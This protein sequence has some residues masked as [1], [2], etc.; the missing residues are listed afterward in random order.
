MDFRIFATECR[1]KKDVISCARAIA[2]EDVWTSAKSLGVIGAKGR[3]VFH[4]R[5]V[6][7]HSEDTT[8]ALS[9]VMCALGFDGTADG[10]ES[11][12]FKPRFGFVLE[13]VLWMRFEEIG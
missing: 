8:A 3:S 4:T 11:D 2:A 6:V 9:A 13:W 10:A 7:V 1:N 5:A 12:H